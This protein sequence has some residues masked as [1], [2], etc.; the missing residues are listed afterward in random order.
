MSSE[1]NN[2]NNINYDANRLEVM[3]DIISIHNLTSNQFTPEPPLIHQFTPEPILN[4]GNQLNP[5]NPLNQ[6][7]PLNPLNL[8]QLNQ[9]NQLTPE[10]FMQYSSPIFNSNKQYTDLDDFNSEF[11]DYYNQTHKIDL[12][13]DIDI[14]MDNNQLNP[15]GLFYFLFLLFFVYIFKN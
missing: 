15:T 9:I 12:N 5:L 6:F 3:N 13:L 8:N 1:L 7:D 4:L 11:D 10:P 14:D 2:S